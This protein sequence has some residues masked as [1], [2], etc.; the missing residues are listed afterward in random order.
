MSQT[1]RFARLAEDAKSR[2]REV[3][4]ADAHGQQA[5]GAVLIDVRESDEFANGHAQGAVHL[6]RGVLELRI[7]GLVP[8]VATPILCY[9]G[10]GSR[11][12]LAAE[13]LQRMGYTNVAS[14]A[15]G[16][17]AWKEQRL[18]TA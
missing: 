7:E 4:P 5:Q 1:T 11:S 2:V 18:P 15:G 16:F 8:D 17:K 12:A 13:S 3:S 9:C 10:G 6:S 14:V